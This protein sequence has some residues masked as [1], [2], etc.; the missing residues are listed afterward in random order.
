M[1]MPCPA[2]CAT[3]GLKLFH[4]DVLTNWQTHAEPE[5]FLA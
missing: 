5:E 3:H 1:S 2:G 4:E